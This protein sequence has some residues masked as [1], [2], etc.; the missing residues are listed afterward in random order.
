[1]D[2]DD[3]GRAVGR[4]SKPTF[5]RGDFLFNCFHFVPI[6]KTN[7]DVDV[8]EPKTWVYVGSYLVV[9]FNDIFDIDI[10]EIVE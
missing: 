2:C 9:G 6:G 10:H 4:I 7:I 1:M 8:F 5:M 3:D